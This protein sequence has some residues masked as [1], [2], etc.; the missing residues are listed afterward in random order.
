MGRVNAGLRTGAA[1]MSEMSFMGIPI[2]ITASDILSFGLTGIVIVF[3]L[4]LGVLLLVLK[5]AEK[6]MKRGRL[7]D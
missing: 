5:I 1:V 7:N 4:G 3:W 6:F 2:V